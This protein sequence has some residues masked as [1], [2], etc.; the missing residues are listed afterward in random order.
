MPKKQGKQASSGISI[1]GNVD[2]GG[3]DIAA[4]DIQKGNVYQT[5]GLQAN[6]IKELFL[7]IYQGI[8]QRKDLPQE[9][10]DDLKTAVEE[11]QVEVAKGEEADESFLERRF[12]NIARMAPDILDVVLKTVANPVLGLATLAQKIASKAEGGMTR[13]D[14]PVKKKPN[15]G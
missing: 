2:T 4:G 5:H 9:D 7:P 3:G 13:Q 1:G 10:R 14:E 11:I 12:R 6:E 8:E 15:Q